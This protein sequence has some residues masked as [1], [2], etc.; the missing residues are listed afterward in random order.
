MFVLSRVLISEVG[1]YGNCH[2]GS[3]HIPKKV[4]MEK[5]QQDKFTWPS[6]EGISRFSINYS[7]YRDVP[8]L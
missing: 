6:L 3:G 7:M 5:L 1:T 4:E 8:K 2:S